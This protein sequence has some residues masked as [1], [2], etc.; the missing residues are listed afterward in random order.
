MRKL[1]TITG[2]TKELLE[3]NHGALEIKVRC[4]CCV[5]VNLIGG[6]EQIL[7]AL[8]DKNTWCRVDFV[9]SRPRVVKPYQIEIY[10]ES[11]DAILEIVDALWDTEVVSVVFHDS[12]TLERLRFHNV[13]SFD[14]SGCPNLEYLDCDGFRGD[15]LNLTDLPRLKSLHCHNGQSSTIE[16]SKSP[17]LIMLDLLRCKMKQLKVSNLLALQKL[18]ID[19]CEHLNPRTREW[20]EQKVGNIPS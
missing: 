5:S 7:T 10:G 16:L 8:P 12:P 6:K 20:M 15:E 14:F 18:N 13:G 19:C 1:I 17:D 2:Q 4:G 9:F 11:A 3:G